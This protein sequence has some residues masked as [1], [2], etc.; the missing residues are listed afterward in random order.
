MSLFKSKI[1][2]RN[3][4]VTGSDSNNNNNSTNSFS[5]NIWFIKSNVC[6]KN[7]HF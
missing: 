7:S 1:L 2:I 5:A 4:A 6:D 3:I